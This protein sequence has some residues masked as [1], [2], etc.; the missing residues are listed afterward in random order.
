MAR[1]TRHLTAPPEA[2]A[3]VLVDGWRYA[4]WVVGAKH[5]RAVDDSWPAPGSRFHHTL[6]VGPLTI[7]DH[8]ELVELSPEKV[9]LLARAWPAGVGRVTVTVVPK[10]GGSLV[11]IDEVPVCGMAKLLDGPALTL[12]TNVR[13]RE[14]LRRLAGAA[15]RPR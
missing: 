10:D 3:A 2:V 5:V 14:S 8:T 1:V 11:S 9:V 13:N 15:G 4:D 12:L 6:G 7:K